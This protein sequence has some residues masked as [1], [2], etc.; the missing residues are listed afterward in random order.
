VPPFSQISRSFSSQSFSANLFR[1]YRRNWH[2][3]L[4]FG[5]DRWRFGRY[6][7]FLIEIR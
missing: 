1:T 3:R 5:L 2:R 6:P 7:D 4:I